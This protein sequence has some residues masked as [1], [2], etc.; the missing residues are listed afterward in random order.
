MGRG[1]A[2]GRQNRVEYKPAGWLNPHQGG[3]CSGFRSLLYSQD[4]THM[5]P[6]ALAGQWISICGCTATASLRHT[7][8][9][10]MKQW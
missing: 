10:R 7:H 1:D 8:F 4:H 9:Y 6:P 2:R 5:A 3:D